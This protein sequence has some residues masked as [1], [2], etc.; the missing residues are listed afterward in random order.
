[1]VEE[2]IT[3]DIARQAR[4]E[5][6]QDRTKMVTRT[7]LLTGRSAGTAQADILARTFAEEMPYRMRQ[8]TERESTNVEDRRF[9]DELID[10]NAPMARLPQAPRMVQEG[11][12]P[13]LPGEGPGPQDVAQRGFLVPLATYKDRTTGQEYGGFAAP[14]IFQDVWDSMKRLQYGVP[15]VAEFDPK[16]TMNVAGAAF[17]GGLT[18]MATAEAGGLGSFGGRLGN[19]AS[20]TS[21]E[22]L[23]YQA[24]EVYSDP[25]R[26]EFRIAGPNGMKVGEYSVTQSSVPGKLTIDNVVVNPNFR[27]QGIA[28]QAYDS[29]IAQVGKDNLTPSATLQEATYQM[30]QRK[31]PELLA[32]GKYVKEADG[33]W[34]RTDDT[35]TPVAAK[36]TKGKLDISAAPDQAVINYPFP[37]GAAPINTVRRQYANMIETGEDLTAA[38]KAGSGIDPSISRDYV[39][40]SKQQVAKKDK[41]LETKTQSTIQ[42]LEKEMPDLRYTLEPGESS[43]KYIVVS[44]GDRKLL[45]VR[46]SDHGATR[47]DSLSIDPVSGNTL[48][49]VLQ[50]LRYERGLT[51]VAP[52]VGWSLL[53]PKTLR[54]RL[55]RE[56][57]MNVFP[58]KRQIGGR[59]IYKSSQEQPFDITSHTIGKDIQWKVPGLE[60]AAE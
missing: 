22:G 58:D 30:W 35:F 1:M 45:K 12:V 52:E 42:A 36:S 28:E 29:V 55:N 31:N 33:V 43:S 3:R 11:D 25:N 32:A 9:T 16:D 48:E 47:F 10:Q 49:T 38:P 56:A 13:Y 46:I 6:L 14:G 7:E 2:V 40:L 15:D 5:D 50:A 60:K 34:V 37:S 53:P 59:G 19:K 41:L 20:L 23:E 24:R 27:R 26:A 8:V 21:K 17:T 54:E 18:R 4:I 57:G 44:D 51:D 39:G